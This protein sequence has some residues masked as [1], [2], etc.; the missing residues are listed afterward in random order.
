MTTY[1][2]TEQTKELALS[3]GLDWQA[4][5]TNDYEREDRYYALCNAAIQSYID[6]LA[7][8]LPEPEAVVFHKGYYSREQLIAAVAKAKGEK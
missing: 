6:S 4:I 2:T 8:G 5:Y 7:E 3:V 1:L